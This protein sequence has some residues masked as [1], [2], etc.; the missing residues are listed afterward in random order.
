MSPEPECQP[1]L[2]LTTW[3]LAQVLGVQAVKV[4]ISIFSP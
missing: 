3:A 4:Q 1:A 2:P